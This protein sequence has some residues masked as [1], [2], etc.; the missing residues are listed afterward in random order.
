MNALLQE[1]IDKAEGDF[2][3]ASREV[4]ARKS[5]NYDAACFHC[6]QCAEKYLKG[7]LVQQ[8]QPF[9]PVHDLIELLELCLLRDGTFEL[10]RDLLKDLTRYAVQFRYPGE[11]ATKE[12]ARAALQVVK[13][14][15][16]FIRSKLGLSSE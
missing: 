5:P 12:D 6:Q 4:R 16:A 2:H 9:R 7:Y 11:M 1:W 15:R 14:V 3:T 13:T 8:G 10:Q